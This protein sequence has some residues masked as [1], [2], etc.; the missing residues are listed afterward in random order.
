MYGEGDR[1]GGGWEGELGGG[2]N[3]LK[4]CFG[5]KIFW[6]SGDLAGIGTQFWNI[7]GRYKRSLTFLQECMTPKNSG[8]FQISGRTQSY[9]IVLLKQRLLEMSFPVTRLEFELAF[10]F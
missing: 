7:A 6:E 10:V 1:G 5:R 2:G 4:A 8:I 9:S 3:N